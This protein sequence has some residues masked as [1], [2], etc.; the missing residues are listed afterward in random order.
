MPTERLLY[1]LE[2]GA[3][4]LNNN[5]GHSSSQP[6]VRNQKWIYHTKHRTVPEDNMGVSAPCE[7]SV[8]SKLSIRIEASSRIT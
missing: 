6:I 4:A 7:H 2:F 3:A 8:H 1:G 5:K